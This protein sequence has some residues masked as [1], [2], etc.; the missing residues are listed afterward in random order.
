[1][2]PLVRVDETS[3]EYLKCLHGCEVCEKCYFDFTI[4]NKLAKQK[5]MGYDLSADM[6]MIEHIVDLH[7]AGIKNAMEND[8]NEDEGF[9]FD[10]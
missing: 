3:Q 2:G 7:F 1:M 6:S 4:V 5:Y 9:T 10:I 8:E